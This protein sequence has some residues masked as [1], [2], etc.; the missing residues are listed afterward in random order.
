MFGRKIDPNERQKVLD[1]LVHWNRSVTRIDESTSRMRLTIAEQPLGMQS[2]EFETARLAAVATV[3]QIRKETSAQQF[4]PILNDDRSMLIMLELQNKLIESYKHQLNLLRLFGAAAEA[5]RSGQNYK[6]PSQ[7]EVT[8]ANSH[9]ARVLDEMG[10]LAGKLARNYRI[11]GREYL[12]ALR[13]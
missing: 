13:R 6:S 8:S 12:T 3:E 4:W 1:L 9:F 11:E 10:A 2:K 7:Q 5:F